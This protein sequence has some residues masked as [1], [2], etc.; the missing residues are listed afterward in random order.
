MWF[1]NLHRVNV[2]VKMCVFSFGISYRK[3]QANKQ[4]LT[5]ILYLFFIKYLFLT[6]MKLQIAFP[7]NKIIFKTSFRKQRKFPF[8]YFNSCSWFIKI[9]LQKRNSSMCVFKLLMC[10]IFN[11]I[12]VGV[13]LVICFN[14]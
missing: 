14:I 3:P 13:F 5:Q 12:N 9:I 7:S 8:G 6:R 4:N 11:R 1:L 10:L 2:L